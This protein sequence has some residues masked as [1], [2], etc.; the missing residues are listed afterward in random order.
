MGYKI[1]SNAHIASLLR[2]VIE[3][4][5]AGVRMLSSAEALEIAR[6]F[7]QTRTDQPL[8]PL[9]YYLTQ[10]VSEL[11]AKLATHEKKK[12]KK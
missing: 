5:E 1:P 12:R 3:E 10:R 8:G 2:K 6:S 4:E 9:V 11:E 7:A